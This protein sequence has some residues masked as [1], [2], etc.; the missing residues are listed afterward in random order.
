MSGISGLLDVQNE[1]LNSE[2][3]TSTP[4]GELGKNEFLEMLV[5]QMQNQDPLEPV[6]NTA[7]IAQMAQFSSLE[8]MSNL[9]DQFEMYQQSTTSIF[10]LMNAGKVVEVELANG[11]VVTGNLDKVQWKDGESQFVIAG[12]AYSIGGIRSMRVVDN[13]LVSEDLPPGPTVTPNI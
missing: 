10:S 2:P 9:N 7:M 6:D 11:E 12:D 8:Q 4:G 3:V 5:T 13:P 1:R